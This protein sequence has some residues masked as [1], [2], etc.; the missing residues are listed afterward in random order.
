MQNAFGVLANNDNDDDS[1]D[2][3]ATQVAAFTLQSQLT[4]SMAANSSQ[5]QDCLYQQMAHQQTLLHAN[6]HQILEQLAALLL[7]TSDA[8]QGHR[9]SG[10][11][12]PAPPGF[13]Q[14]TT[15]VAGQAMQVNTRFGGRG[16]GQ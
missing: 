16:R 10:G 3:I 6:Q 14:P 9:C 11:R 4:A 12:A 2:T 1:A 13:P 7:N 15:L 8:G 5:H